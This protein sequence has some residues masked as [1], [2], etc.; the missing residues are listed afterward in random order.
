VTNGPPERHVS[1]GRA[2]VGNATANAVGQIFGKL[3]TLAWTI[4]AARVLTRAEF[5]GFSLA[6]SVA[7]LV[8][9]VAEW[10]F[11]VLLVRRA[12]ADPQQ[13]GRLLAL[14]ITCQLLVGFP[15]FA[16]AGVVSALTRHS[17]KSAAMFVL[18]LA[19]IYVELWNDSSRAA[20]AAL[21]MQTPTVVALVCQR[22]VSAALIITALA[23][24][25]GLSGLGLT[26][27]LGS[28]VGLVAHVLAIRRVGIRLRFRPLRWADLRN[29]VRGTAVFGVNS[30]VLIALARVDAI[31][32]SVIKGDS[33]LGAYA[34]AYRLF[35]TTLFLTFAV[36]SSVLPVMSSRPE[37][38]RV[39][40][41]FAGSFNAVLVAYVPFA[42]VCLAD[43]PG[44][45]RLF[46]GDQ[47]AGAAAGSMRWLAL[48][49]AAFALAYLAVLALTALQKTRSLL[50]ASVSATVAN[51]A[52]NLVLIPAYS[53]TGAGAANTLS[54]A[55][56]GLIVVFALVRCTGRLAILDIIVE[57]FLAG[58]ALAVFLVL[59]SAPFLLEV[60]AGLVIYAAVW[61][62]VVR[63]R[64]PDRLRFFLSLLRP[65]APEPAP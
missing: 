41:L 24:G 56:Q 10:G 37:P 36:S 47:Y 8:T 21:H 64:R 27:F 31:L 62:G 32:L 7:L 30:L 26:F 38:R 45:L 14:A 22:A 13:A 28:V 60:P 5:G 12:S 19:A 65:T 16:A 63:W 17:G 51:V 25:W 52:L 34:A 50:V 35:E 59:V 61:A 20:A 54:Y 39:G 6:L 42:I 15:V 43:A 46:Y 33:A 49:P 53:G 4:V 3:T 29:Y 44:L 18:V 58:A 11:D 23:L 57:P 55:L 2:I 40:G 9:V 1:D 48:S